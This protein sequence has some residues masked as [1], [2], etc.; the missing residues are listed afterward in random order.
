VGQNIFTRPQILFFT[1]LEMSLG[2]L[3]G[4]SFQIGAFPPPL[5]KRIAGVVK[6]VP[7]RR[8]RGKLLLHRQGQRIDLGEGVEQI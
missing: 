3:F 7:G 1:R 5:V 6:F 8:Q 2:D 4:L